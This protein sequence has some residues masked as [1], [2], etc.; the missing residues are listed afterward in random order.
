MRN[1]KMTKLDVNRR[2]GESERHCDD[3][4]KS[5]IFRV[6]TSSAWLH[7]LPREQAVWL[8]KRCFFKS[9]LFFADHFYCWFSARLKKAA[10]QMPSLNGI[11]IA[12]R[13][14]TRL[15]V[16]WPHKGWNLKHF[17][18]NQEPVWLITPA[19]LPE[20]VNIEGH[21]NSVSLAAMLRFYREIVNLWIEHNDY[22]C[23]RNSRRG[24]KWFGTRSRNLIPIAIYLGKYPR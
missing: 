19:R 10:K 15:H 7:T 9:D 24:R 3:K 11:T 12:D 6:G 13:F 1:G 22:D 23:M 16:D 8:V 18:I 4:R 14:A 5:W 20:S 17:F 21:R 2:T